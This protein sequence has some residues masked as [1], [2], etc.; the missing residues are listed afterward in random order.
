MI[1][2][3]NHLNTSPLDLLELKTFTC[4]LTFRLQAHKPRKERP[5]RL[6]VLLKTSNEKNI[7]T[8]LQNRI[9]KSKNT[10]SKNI[11]IKLQKV[12]TTQN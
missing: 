2:I 4:F 7:K 6:I 5:E 10:K 1:G 3:F 11:T 8:K 9:I 12:E